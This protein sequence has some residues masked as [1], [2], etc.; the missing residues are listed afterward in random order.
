MNKKLNVFVVSVILV[1]ATLVMV[2]AYKPSFSF[3]LPATA[4]ADAKYVVTQPNPDLTDEVLTTEITTD[5][6]ASSLSRPRN[7]GS[8]NVPWNSVFG[9]TGRF[10]DLFAN[11]LTSLGTNQNINLTPLGTGKVLVGGGS[12]RVGQLSSDPSNPENGLIYYDSTLGKFKFFENG[13]FKTIPENQPGKLLQVRFD[14]SESVLYL[15]QNQSGIIPDMSVVTTTGNNNVK[16][17]FTLRVRSLSN[18]GAP[19]T[20][21]SNYAFTIDGTDIR[22]YPFTVTNGGNESNPVDTYT[23][24]FVTPISGGNHTFQVRAFAGGNHSLEVLD[25]SMLV[26]EEVVQ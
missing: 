11:S 20:L 4:P 24:V 22:S 25:Q 5:L 7:L 10:T 13:V 23:A 17:T 26:V 19:S 3:A 1:L 18:S 15:N 12:L 6:I 21:R 9:L 8:S 16:L 14:S 2:V